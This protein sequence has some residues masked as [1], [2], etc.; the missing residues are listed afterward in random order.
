[1]GMF[2]DTQEDLSLGSHLH[3]QQEYD[4]SCWTIPI[5]AIK[6]RDQIVRFD[7]SGDIEYIYEVL[8]NTKEKLIFRHY[9]RQRLSLKRMDKTDI[10]YTFPFEIPDSI[11]KP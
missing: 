8:H 4:P 3:L 10:I 9:S 1:M 5:P 11:F 7:F 2:A 6:D